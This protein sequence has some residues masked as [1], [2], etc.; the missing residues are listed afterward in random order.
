MKSFF[1]IVNGCLVTL[2]FFLQLKT[3]ILKNKQTNKIKMKYEVKI[4]QEI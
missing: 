2:S 3:Q 4:S 1:C